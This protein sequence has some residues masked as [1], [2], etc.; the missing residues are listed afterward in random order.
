MDG[1]IFAN[2][3][4]FSLKNAHQFIQ[5]LAQNIVETGRDRIHNTIMTVVVIAFF[6]VDT[7]LD[8]HPWVRDFDPLRNGTNAE[9]C[10]TTVDL[11]AVERALD[12]SLDL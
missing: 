2:K 12:V 9:R 6:G 7:S 11:L 4:C 5:L 3:R 8:I 10:L 1:T